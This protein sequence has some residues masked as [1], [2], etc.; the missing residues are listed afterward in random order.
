[1]KPTV[2]LLAA[3]SLLT[4]ASCQIKPNPYAAYP[5]VIHNGKPARIIPAWVVMN[6]K[7]IPTPAA[8]HPQKT[9]VLVSLENKRAWLYQEGQPVLQS[10]ICSGKPKHETPKGTF[11][12][13][14]KH[15]HWISTLYHVPMPLFLRLN[16]MGGK[17]GLHAGPIATQNASHGCIR[18]PTPLAEKFFEHC[19]VGTP[20]TIQ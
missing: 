17:I 16:C 18:L 15:R 11:R 9:C 8:P 20:V 10:P 1:M 4:A 6:E 2:A 7:E 13:I 3:T 14:A 19:Q 5:R 12:V